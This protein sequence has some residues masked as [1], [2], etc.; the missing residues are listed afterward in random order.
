MIH[1][2]I[3]PTAGGGRAARVGTEIVTI[4]RQRGIAH[5]S[6]I[7]QHPGEA[8]HLA[9]MAAHAGAEIVFAVG[10]DGTVLETGRGLYGTNAALGIIPSGTGNDMIKT[11]GIPKDPLQ[12]LE[13]QLARPA[14]AL[15]A[16][17]VNGTLSLNVTGTGFDVAVLDYADKAKKYV[18]GLLPYLWGVLRT[19]ISFRTPEMEISI[20]GVHEK[21]RLLIIALANGQFIGGGIHVAPMARTDDGLLTVVTVDHLPNWRMPFQLPKLLTGKIMNIPGAKVGACRRAEISCKNMRLDIDGEIVPMEHAVIEILPA[22][23]KAHW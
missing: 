16:M 7:T 22:A 13:Y 5:S 4:L 18:H 17:S 10:G 12:A 8:E 6:S 9:H 1:L 21:K 19:I 14:R 20:D 3:N 23:L 11:L 15:D 2:V